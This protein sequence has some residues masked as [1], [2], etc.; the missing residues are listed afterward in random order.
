LREAAKVWA[1]V[2]VNSFGG[3][4]GQ[5]AVMHRE[6]V[7]DRRWIGERRFLH[8]LNYCMVLPGPEA[9]QLAT[10]TGWLL[11]GVRGGV[12]AGSLF[13]LPGFVVMM[14]LSAA[15]ALFGGVTWV[16]GLFFGVQAAVV[17]IVVQAMIRLGSRTLRS[18]FLGLV[19]VAAFVALF[20][21]AV[22]FPLVIV[23]AGV[24]GWAA[25]RWADRWLPSGQEQEGAAPST[26]TLLGD[27]ERV[28]A[29]A[30]RRALHAAAVCAVLWLVPVLLLVL[31]LGSENVFAQ[32][33]VL[34]S[35]AAV[36]TF[37]G[38]YAVL[39]YISQQ[40]VQT[41]GWITADDMTTG[42]G[43]AETTPG[44]LIMVV[45]FVGFL[46]A[47][48]NPG[49]LPPLVAGVLGAVVTVWVTF[50]PCF[51][52]IFAGAP[53]VDRLRH[54]RGLHDALSGIGAA[55][56]GVIGNLALWF[57]LS[58][59]FTVSTRDFGPVTVT[60]PDV[61]SLDLAALLV[62]V[63]AVVLVFRLRWSTLRVLAVCAGLGVTAA[64][65]GLG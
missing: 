48:N 13:V 52:F 50:V 18:R 31:T 51:M 11:N 8:A 6:V 60:V 53:Y 34:F 23:V 49:S 55:V 20:L 59:F 25:G 30:A 65:L 7:D 22:P 36:V 64:V 44:P 12:I 58:T 39:A 29:A 28:P 24:V 45:Q 54:N 10:Y 43:L 63:V 14:L 40:A 15:Y 41:Y 33:A 35:K 42:L 17:A 27:D 3:P 4:A 32:Q 38:A 37:G 26:A 16:S 9:Q 2:G 46:A 1:Y 19:A 61:G 62:A 56:V 57:A 47:Y 5:I 21:F